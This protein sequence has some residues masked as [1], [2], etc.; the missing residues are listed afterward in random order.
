MKFLD[1]CAGIGGGKLGLESIGWDCIGYSEIDKKAINTYT[2]L[3][4]KKEHNYGDLMTID[5]DKLPNFDVMIAGFPC[6]SFSIVGLRQG[7][8]DARGQIIYGIIDILKNK[9]TPYFILENVKGLVNHN[10]GKTIKVISEELDRAGYQ[11]C[12]KVLNSLNYG[13]PQ[14][15]ERVYFVGIH[16]DFQKNSPF[17]WPQEVETPD[18]RDYLIDTENAILNHH[19]DETFKRYL[20]NKYNKNKFDIKELLEEDYLV[21]DTRQSDLRLYRGAVPTLRAGR[22]GILYVKDGKLRKLTGYESL[23]LQGFPKKMASEIKGRIP[24]GHLLSQAGN[25]MTVTT[26]AK[27]GEQ[28]S[29]YIRGVDCKWVATGT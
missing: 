19:T 4:G 5:P 3:Y 25:A 26:I 2:L 16:K 9:A 8:K 10:K 17:F 15:R 23:L 6:Q 21:I 7:L 24:E 14:M 28:L 20:N 11:T 18:I 12:Y 13:V 1:V 27:I 22:H 29:K